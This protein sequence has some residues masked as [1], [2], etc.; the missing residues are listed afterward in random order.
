MKVKVEKDKCFGCSACT[1]IS[2][3][4]FTMDDD[5]LATV[6]LDKDENGYANVPDNNKDEVMAAS[7]SCPG[8]AINVEE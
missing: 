5:G 2:P 3:D 8:T 1:S 7:E 6:K 4:T